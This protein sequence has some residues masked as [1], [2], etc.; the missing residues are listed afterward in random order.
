MMMTKTAANAQSVTR[1]FFLALFS[2]L[3]LLSACGKSSS[4]G[5]ERNNVDLPT[6]DSQPFSL[7]CNNVGLFGEDCVLED[8]ENPYARSAVTEDNKFQLDADAPSSTARFYLWATALARSAGAGGE[9]Q[10]YVALNL[11]RMWAA[12]DSEIT[13]K[14]ALRAYQS[15]LDNFLNS[16]TFFEIPVG[17]GETFPFSLDKF[18]GEMLFDPADTDNTFTSARLFNDDP[19]INRSLANQQVGEWGFFF[20]QDAEIFTEFP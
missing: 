4:D 10:F 14:Q 13:R 12:S 15:Y 20:D 11:H 2:S 16:V 1:I 9:N 7:Y 8:P 18:S 19:D 5:D 17:S 3:L 6:D